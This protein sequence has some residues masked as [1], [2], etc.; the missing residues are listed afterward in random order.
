MS[1]PASG[2]LFDLE[3][4]AGRAA[5]HAAP[6]AWADWPFGDLVPGGY[7]FVW[8]DPPWAYEM[9]GASGYAKSPQAHYAC[10]DIEDL[11]RLP[12]A[13]L[14]K[15]DSLL[16]LWTTWPHLASG[17]ALALVKAWGFTGKTGFPWVKETVNGKLAFGTGYVLRSCTEPV[18]IAAR[19]QPALDREFTGRTRAI[20]QAAVREHSR[21]P[22]S[23]YRIAEQIMPQARRV[24]LFGRER[25][26]GWDLFGNEPDK[27]S[28]GEA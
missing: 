26:S 16:W 2:T 14:A 10:V 22:E 23:A 28:K 11:K 4:S 13:K 18:I 17:Q 9:R 19:G 27:F 5:H 20:I 25:R 1:G 8:A 6:V 3:P 15:P 24:D 12:V 21:K 7:D